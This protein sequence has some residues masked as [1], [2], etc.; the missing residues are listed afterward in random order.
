[1]SLTFSDLSTDAGLKQLNDYM[2]GRTFV[3]GIAASKADLDLVALVKKCPDCAKYP[4]A[5]RWWNYISGFNDAEKKAFKAYSLSVGTKSVEGSTKEAEQADDDS[6]DDL[7]GSDDEEEEGAIDLAAEAA[8][9]AEA[10]K[11]DQKMKP[12]LRSQIVFDIK[13]IDT[14]VDLEELAD[15]IKEIV[16]GD[17]D[18]YADRITDFDDFRVTKDNICTWG[19]GHEIQPIAFGIEKLCISCCVIDEMLGVDDVKDI[20]EAKF[21]EKIQSVDVR[22]FNKAEA[23]KAPKKKKK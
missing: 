14:E 22:A 16:V 21:G 20:L 13:P 9:A 7:F 3:F 6:D 4:A 11:A 10:S 17:I 2:V 15:E 19:V 5:A 8:K 23:I 12:I 1:M 18:Q